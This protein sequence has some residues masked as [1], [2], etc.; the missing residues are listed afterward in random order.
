MKTEN[1]DAE[2]ALKHL[3]QMASKGDNEKYDADED[4]LI[5][6][7]QELDSAIGVV[8]DCLVDEM[9]ATDMDR[10]KTTDSVRAARAVQ[11]DLLD[12][13]EELD[14]RNHGVK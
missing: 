14:V 13:I 8:E 5:S 3:N 9:F 7:E 1:D 12:R 10:I 4:T 2:S 6:I 11:N